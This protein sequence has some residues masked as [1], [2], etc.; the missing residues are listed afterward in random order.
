[1]RGSPKTL[2]AKSGKQAKFKLFLTFKCVIPALI[3]G[4]SC[5]NGSK[6]L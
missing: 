3:Y 4:R 6:M 5:D 2:P 1:M